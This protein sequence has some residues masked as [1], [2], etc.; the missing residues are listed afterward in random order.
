MQHCDKP[1]KA[2]LFDVDGTLIDTTEFILQAYEYTLDSENIHVPGVRKKMK[3]LFGMPLLDCYRIL[4]PDHDV[5]RLSAIHNQWQAENLH[6]VGA[7]PTVAETVQSLKKNGLKVA[8]VTNRARPSTIAILTESGIH[9]EI[10]LIIGFED[11]KNPKP[12]P[13]GIL[14]ALL[15]FGLEPGEVVMIGDSEFDILAGKAAQVKT[16]GVRTGL[17]P[18]QMEASGPDHVV[19]RIAEIQPLL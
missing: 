8:T 5:A 18:E 15:Y 3:E 4:A 16:I 7:F 2:V 19:E 11:V 17:H 12:H 10:D 14:K 9:E 13:E 6:M 1:V